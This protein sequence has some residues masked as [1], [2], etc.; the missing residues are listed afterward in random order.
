M[1]NFKTG[2][3]SVL[4]YKTQFTSVSTS[5]ATLNLD[6][7]GSNSQIVYIAFSII[8]I[9]QNN[10]DIELGS[11][12]LSGQ[13]ASTVNYF[14][15]YASNKFN[16]SREIPHIQMFHEWITANRSYLSITDGARYYSWLDVASYSSNVIT[17]K[18]TA[19]LLFYINGIKI[20][21]VMVAKSS[22]S[23]GFIPTVYSSF[24]QK[25]GLMRK[26]FNYNFGINASNFGSE[27]FG[28]CILGLY[29]LDLYVYSLSYYTSDTFFLFSY[30]G[31]EVSDIIAYKVY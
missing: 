15:T 1:Y 20:N 28:Y 13:S 16:F 21:I 6:L 26:I 8:V 24:S 29:V 27:S 31:A 4:S 7:V 18:V 12:Q 22:A 11:M 10:S 2:M 3:N 30:N 19:D 5:S 23:Q 25:G 9:T 17:V 14:L